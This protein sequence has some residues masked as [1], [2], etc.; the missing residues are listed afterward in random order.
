MKERIKSLFDRV[1]NL[2]PKVKYTAFGFVIFAIAALVIFGLSQGRKGHLREAVPAESLAYFEVRDAGSLLRAM[3]KGDRAKSARDFSMFD[4]MDLAV[5]VSGFETSEQELTGEQ[6]VLNLR[7]KFG[8]VA[9]TNR[10]GWQSK[11]L[12][13][14]PLNAFVLKQMG[15]AARRSTKAVSYG[16]L[17]VWTASD[18][19]Q[20]FAIADGSRVYFG[21]DEPFLM[22]CLAAAYGQKKG[23]RDQPQLESMFE[24]SGEV[25]VLGWIPKRAINKFAGLAGVSA[26]VSG[27]EDGGIRGFISRVVP[28]IFNNSVESI[29]WTSRQSSTGLS[30]EVRFHT[31]DDISEV[32]AETMKTGKADHEQ[33]VGFIPPDSSSVTRYSLEKPRI[34][35]RSLILVAGKNV[36][37]ASARLLSLFSIALLGS[38]GVSDPESF[39]DSVKGEIITLELN[40]TERSS[41]AMAAVK[42]RES[43]LAAISVAKPGAA[44]TNMVE[45]GEYWDDGE[46]FAAAIVDGIVISGDKKAVDECLNTKGKDARNNLSRFDEF[47]KSLAPVTT[48]SEETDEYG[49]LYEPSGNAG[50]TQTTMYVSETMFG[51]EGITR[52][53]DSKYGLIGALLVRIAED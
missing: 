48:V 7:F 3:T 52:R 47:S 20:T 17:S 45:N 42:N 26:A 8:A 9:E 6:S 27:S 10:W 41:A 28:Q 19:R 38:Y 31:K 21:N 25:F 11:G 22:N 34:A 30:D 50:K 43:V 40:D 2:E 12:I 35:Y 53:Y 39:L 23:L 15:N 44:K 4:G 37:P 29:T 33:I 24:D 14:G 46:G 13:D 16:S 1:G 49:F 51:K 5:A 18:G 36:D 32:F